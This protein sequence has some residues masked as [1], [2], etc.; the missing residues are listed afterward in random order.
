M[1][2]VLS[3]S[4]AA[5][6]EHA[7]RREGHLRRTHPPGTDDTAD[8]AGRLVLMLAVFTVLGVLACQSW[9]S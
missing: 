1:I 5:Q 7:H 9:A 4:A 8:A 2:E 6:L 3:A